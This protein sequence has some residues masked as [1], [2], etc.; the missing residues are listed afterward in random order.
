MPRGVPKAG[1]R[2]TKNSLTKNVQAVTQ[3]TAPVKAVV[4]ETDEQITKKLEERFN[5]LDKMSNATLQGVN[6]SLIVSGPAGLG[7]SF[8]VM[9]AAEEYSENGHEVVVIKGFVRPTGLYK[10]LYENR[11]PHCVVIFD[12]ADSIFT[13]DISMNILKGACDMTE[14]RTLH[15]LAETKMEDEDGDRLPRSFDFEGSIIFITNYD[16]DY[17]IEKGT[18]LAPH[19]QA[20]ISR[21][22]Y[23]DLEMKTVRDYMMRIKQVL[24]IMVKDQGLT[25]AE[26]YQLEKFIETNCERLRELSLRMVVKLATLMKMDR[27]GW[28]QM[29][30]VTCFKNK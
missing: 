9:K 6:R 26:G 19:F 27:R 1:F 8:S 24:P 29:A 7:K 14:K 30:R 4:F 21:S 3:F 12:D 28:E 16:F 22:I 20:L 13:D 5:A 2:K 10:V 17:M 18:R 15:W 11:H 25:V 23:L